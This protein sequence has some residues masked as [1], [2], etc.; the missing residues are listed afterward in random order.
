MSSHTDEPADLRSRLAANLRWMFT[1]LPFEA[2][3]AAA[4][5]AGFAAVEYPAP[6]AYPAPELV[7]RLA[8]AG[9]RQALVNSPMGAAGTPTERGSACVPGARQEF[10]QSIESALEYATALD[11]GIV[12]V[13]AGLR[14]ADV[15]WER[16]FAEY[17]ENIA[18]AAEFSAGTDVTLVLEA[19]NSTD[20]PGFLVRT[21]DQTAAVVE[22][23]DADNV[24]LLFDV[25][26]VQMEQGNVS[27]AFAR[28]RPLVA[29]IQIADAPGRHQ[30]GAGELNWRRIFPLIA[31]TGYRGWIGCEYA[32]QPDTASSL[33]WITETMR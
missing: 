2:R 7:R 16:A 20:V 6:Y 24:R 33:G 8:D 5:E 18:W 29:H 23:I 32:P 30:P 28:L 14:P 12:H 27:D 21:Q 19:Q 22:A 9:L 10:R 25:Y 3:F 1:E 11:C 26:H 4:A 17:V 15:S 31:S 13:V